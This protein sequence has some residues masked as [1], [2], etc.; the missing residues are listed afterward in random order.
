MSRLAPQTQHCSF[1]NEKAI[2]DQISDQVLVQLRDNEL[3][4]KLLT[5]GDLKLDDA[6]KLAREHEAAEQH[7]KGMATDGESSCG[8]LFRTNAISSS[9]NAGRYRSSSKPSSSSNTC[10]NCERTGHC[11]KGQACPVRG[12]TCSAS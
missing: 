1:G 6:L 4:K 10:F 11:T 7:A 12:K 3:R 2:K 5:L 8:V 9:N